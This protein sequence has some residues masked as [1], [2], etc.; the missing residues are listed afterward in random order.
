MMIEVRCAVSDVAGDARLV[1]IS[2]MTSLTMVAQSNLRA[3][4]AASE[5]NTYY[6]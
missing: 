6:S 5:P 2:Q 3:V 1:K 4:C